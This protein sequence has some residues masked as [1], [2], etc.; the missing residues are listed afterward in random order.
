VDQI[1]GERTKKPP[2]VCS[3]GRI[4]TAICDFFA[5]RRHLKTLKEFSII[6]TAAIILKE[7][8]QMRTVHISSDRTVAMSSDLI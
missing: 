3:R 2:A 1:T 4:E 8:S 7:F 5:V 6:A